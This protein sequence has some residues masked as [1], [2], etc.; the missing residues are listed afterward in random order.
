MNCKKNI[1]INKYKYYIYFSEHCFWLFFFNM[2]SLRIKDIFD[3][4]M[5]KTL[6]G[7]Q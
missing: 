2:I 5:S 4:I 7:K 3:L 1:N 6:F